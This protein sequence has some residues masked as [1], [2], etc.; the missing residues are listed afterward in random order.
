MK[1]GIQRVRRF[2]QTRQ[3][4]VRGG[5]GLQLE[6]FYKKKAEENKTIAGRYGAELTNSKLS[7]KRELLIS[8]KPEDLVSVPQQISSYVR[9]QLGVELEEQFRQQNVE[10]NSRKPKIEKVN[11]RVEIAKVSGVGSD[12]IFKIKEI[13]ASAPAEV[14]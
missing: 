7:E 5:L 11:T 10:S 13:K 9:G 1:T 4:Y 6:G 3:N 8:T 2:L 14:H 12:T